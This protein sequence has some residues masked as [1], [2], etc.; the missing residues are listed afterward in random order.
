[1]CIY[2]LYVY[3]YMRLHDNKHNQTESFHPLSQ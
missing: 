1:M 3:I 2:I